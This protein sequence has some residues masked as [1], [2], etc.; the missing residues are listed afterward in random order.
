MEV[1]ETRRR[2]RRAHW[3]TVRTGAAGVACRIRVRATWVTIRVRLDPNPQLELEV[4]EGLEKED[5]S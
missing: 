3:R 2:R 5:K 4:P 1:H